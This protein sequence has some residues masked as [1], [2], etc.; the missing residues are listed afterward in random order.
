[1]WF[2]WRWRRP[3]TAP[4]LPRARTASAWPAHRLFLWSVTALFDVLFQLYLF[5][6]FPLCLKR[7]RNALHVCHTT[8]TPYVQCLLYIVL[9]VRCRTS[10]TWTGR[11]SK[12]GRRWWRAAVPAPRRQ[13]MT[14]WMVWTP[15]RL[16]SSEAAITDEKL[17]C[18]HCN[19]HKFCKKASDEP[20]IEVQIKAPSVFHQSA[21]FSTQ[22]R[23]YTEWC[24]ALA[25]FHDNRENRNSL[26]EKSRESFFSW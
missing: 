25:G 10:L 22:P 8:P 19:N 3:A 17:G 18:K 9:R 14:K 4:W 15:P 6:L 5:I 2:Y 20:F 11:C 1:M 26:P 24:V 23:P 7:Y 21:F 13:I 12:D 16:C